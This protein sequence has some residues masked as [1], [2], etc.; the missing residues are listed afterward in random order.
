MQYKSYL[1]EQNTDN[2]NENLILFYGENLGLKNDLKKEIIKKNID[3]EK[4]NFLQDDIIKNEDFF[5]GELM[6]KSLFEQKKIYFIEQ[7]NDK[8]LKLIE[9]IEDKIDNQKIFIFSEILDKRSKLRTFFENSKKCGVVPCY[10][11]NEIS[12]KKIILNKLNSFQGLTT[13]NVNLIINNSNL[14]RN[15]LNNELNKIITFFT[16]KKIVDDKLELLLDSKINENF[17]LLKDEALNGNKIKT[18]ELLSETIIE[19]EKNILYLN[20][21]N[22]R[23]NK[24]IDVSKISKS[25]N[26]EEAINKIRPPIFW[27]DKNTFLFQ[28]KKWNLSKINNILNKTYELEIKIKSNA[29]INKNILMRKLLVDICVLANA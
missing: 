24:L 9:E 27:K 23:L 8:I 12:I 17:N 13:H 25:K 16:D 1:V 22:Q 4:M 11:D 14:N 10:A 26:L 19:P 5:F 15:R 18:N 6:N 29:A 28:A 7:A 3:A 21:I 20:L 2:L